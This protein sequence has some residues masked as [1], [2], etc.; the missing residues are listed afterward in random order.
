MKT[1]EFEMITLS[2]D[3][4]ICTR[5]INLCTE[6]IARVCTPIAG[7]EH[8]FIVGKTEVKVRYDNDKQPAVIIG[9]KTFTPVEHLNYTTDS[10]TWVL[11]TLGSSAAMFLT[12]ESLKD[13]AIEFAYEIR[14]GLNSATISAKTLINSYS[15]ETTL[16]EFFNEVR[17]E[18]LD[19]TWLFEPL[20]WDLDVRM[21]ET[22]VNAG[23]Q[24]G[25]VSDSLI[26][27]YT[28]DELCQMM[29]EFNE[30]ERYESQI[31]LSEIIR[32]IPQEELDKR[33]EL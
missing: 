14:E 31:F 22:L 4:G 24:S 2:E 21:M 12:G 6:E 3:T 18:F 11:E 10:I 33:W 13:C 19:M 32:A 29:Q 8:L 17:H 7:Q 9:G 1:Y 20:M 26:S 15:A 16:L 28:F 23:I 27:T 25:T 5:N 30:E